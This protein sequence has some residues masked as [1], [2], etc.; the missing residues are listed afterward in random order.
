[1]EFKIYKN[2]LLIKIQ[3]A[4]ACK[5]GIDSVLN[6]KNETELIQGMKIY[7]AWLYQHK[8][9]TNSEFKNLILNKF[10]LSEV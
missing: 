2:E 5:A 10:K 7:C 1:M 4:N 9:I 8:I 3:R 6:S